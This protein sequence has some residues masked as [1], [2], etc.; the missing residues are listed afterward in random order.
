MCSL[1]C[2]CAHPLL[3][4]DTL[5]E[6][7]LEVLDEL[8]HTLLVRCWEVLPAIHL[9]DSHTEYAVDCAYRTLP[10]WTWLLLT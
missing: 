5:T 7:L 6:C 10:T 1:L 9:T 4:V 2:L 8:E 3:C